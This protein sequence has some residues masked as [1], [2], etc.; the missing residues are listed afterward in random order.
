MQ[1]ARFDKFFLLD[2]A[3][4]HVLE[5]I[6]ELQIYEDGCVAS[7]LLSKSRA[8]KASYTRTKRHVSICF[9]PG[10][11]Q[12]TPSSPPRAEQGGDWFRVGSETVYR[13]LVPFREAY[14]NL[15]GEIL[16]HPQAA[17]AEAYA[18]PDR[19]TDVPLGSP[20]PLDAAF[21]AACVWAQRYTG[22]VAFPVG[23]ESRAIFRPTREGAR[24]AVR[25]RPRPENAPDLIFD[26]WLLGTEDEVYEILSGVRMR[27]VSGGR[28][29]PPGWIRKDLRDGEA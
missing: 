2:R 20:F 29:Q 5:A 8:G 22:I 13:E 15:R 26:M 6:H 11:P 7:A 10:G 24:Y 21:H 17:Q 1:E 18:P 4:P 19:T 14:H 25:V 12:N 9:A 23:F 28:M 27:D 16:L 3:N